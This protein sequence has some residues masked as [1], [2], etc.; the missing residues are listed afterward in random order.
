VVEYYN[1]ILIEHYSEILITSDIY[2]DGSN[3]AEY[4]KLI[5]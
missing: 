1:E 3:D 4:H 2:D 5:S